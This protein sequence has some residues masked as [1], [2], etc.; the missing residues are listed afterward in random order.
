MSTQVFI[1]YRRD[2]G[3]AMAY[4]LWDRLLARG[5]SI[6]FD[7]DSLSS[8]RFDEKILREI[9]NSSHVIVV[10]P[11]GGLDRCRDPEDWVRKEVSHALREGKQ[12][13]PVRLRGFEWPPDLP[14][15]IRELTRFNWIDMSDLRVFPSKLDELE[16]ALGEMPSLPDRS[17]P[18]AESG[19]RRI[20]FWSDLNENDNTGLLAQLETMVDSSVHFE[21][22]KDPLD[23]LRSLQ[24]DD[25]PDTI[26]L[27]DTDVTKLVSNAK[28]LDRL[29]E[30]LSSFVRD[31]GRLVCT[32]D[33]IYR[34]T[35]NAKLQ[36]LF[37]CKVTRFDRRD[38]VVYKKTDECRSLGVFPGLPDRFV[39]HDGEVCWIENPPPGVKVFFRDEAGRP[40]VF[41]RKR[42]RG[43]CIWL[44]TGDSTEY[45]PATILN[46]DAEFFALL[47]DC[48][49]LSF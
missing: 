43:I 36:D 15:D 17:A 31:G 41:A 2:G 10:L 49:D 39:L 7:I 26:V 28:A 13:V 33:L 40:L 29:N 44:N 42:G 11:K 37:G 19:S 6:F 18:R 9:G 35:K 30:E 1:S 21:N 12:L 20:L 32:H 46:P 14:E 24:R 38:E 23:I 45:A 16:K 3:D 34:R 8:G 47:R 5:Y 4:L 48:I 22:L 27:V 25:P